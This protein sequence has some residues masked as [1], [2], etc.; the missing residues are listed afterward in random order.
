MKTLGILVRA[1]LPQFPSIE[2]PTDW[3][4]IRKTNK[5]NCFG[6]NFRGLYRLA[7]HWDTQSQMRRARGARSPSRQRLAD[8]RRPPRLFRVPP[9]DFFATFMKISLAKFADLRF[10]ES[11]A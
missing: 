4:P 11:K 7:S 8:S 5:I 2:K 6:V 1:G 3:H 9:C 10:I